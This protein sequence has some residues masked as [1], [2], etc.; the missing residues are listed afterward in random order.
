MKGRKIR[1]SGMASRTFRNHA[2]NSIIFNLIKMLLHRIINSVQKIDGFSELHKNNNKLQYNAVDGVHGQDGCKE[3]KPHPDLDL[4]D[5][6]FLKR[7]SK[8]HPLPVSTI[9]S[10]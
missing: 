2:H 7:E 3:L 4:N 6:V 8:G 9:L 10:L 5:P 1:L